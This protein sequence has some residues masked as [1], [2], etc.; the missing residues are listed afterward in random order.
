MHDQIFELNALLKFDVL[1]I[2]NEMGMDMVRF[3][4]CLTDDAEQA[5]QIAHD[6]Q[7]AREF[8]LTSTPS[9]ALGRVDSSGFLRVETLFSGAQP[10]SFFQQVISEF[11]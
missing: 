9:F 8:R 2:A 3:D 6:V 11:Q 7:K 4:Q 5:Q 10:F 1:S